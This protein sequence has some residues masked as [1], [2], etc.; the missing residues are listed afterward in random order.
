MSRNK[1]FFIFS[2]T[3]LILVL[4][5]E[6]FSSHIVYSYHLIDDY[7]YV[8]NQKLRQLNESEKS[9][10]ILVFGSSM[11]REGI[12]PEILTKDLSA[13]DVFKFSVTRGKPMDFYLMWRNIREEKREEAKL[14]IISLSPWMFSK[15]LTLHTEQEEGT[16]VFFKSSAILALYG[17]EAW[18][19]DWFARQ[20][21]ASVSS[22]YRYGDYID[23]MLDHKNL[24]LWKFKGERAIAKAPP[25][26]RYSEN[27]PESYFLEQLQNKENLR[28]YSLS[29]YTWD[30]KENIQMRALQQLLHELQQKQIPVLVM[31]MAVNPYRKQLYESGLEEA[32]KQFVESAVSS[33]GKLYDFSSSYDKENFIDFSHLNPKG[34]QQFSEDLREIIVEDYAL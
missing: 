1:S 3:F 12:D 4:L 17:R 34:R 14:V 21:V 16:R 18:N 20:S 8:A 25:E 2:T 5:I 15:K 9:D 13:F 28:I 26:Y 23:Q 6:I 22:F 11:S 19:L 32:Y 7:Y 10:K 27:K 24:S 33:Y 29:N 31:D 30:I